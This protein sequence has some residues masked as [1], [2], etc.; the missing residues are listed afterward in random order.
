MVYSWKNYSYKVPAQTVG[1]E[2]KKIEDEY[3]K[4][5]NDLVLQKAESEESPLHSLFEWDDAVA[6]HKYRLQQA[7]MLIIN[8]ACEEDEVKQPPKPVRAYYNVSEDTK[9]G[10]FVNMKSAFSNPESR[11]LILKRALKELE[12][13]KE[14]YQNLAELAGV[15]TKIDEILKDNE[16]ESLE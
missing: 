2:F 7:T 9:K 8:L 6:G 14:K 10:T 16:S 1:K 15:F 4:L 12:A 3:G 13:F 11:D 5:T